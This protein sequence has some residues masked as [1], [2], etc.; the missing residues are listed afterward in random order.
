MLQAAG[1]ELQ[2]VSPGDFESLL[3][4]RLRAMRPSLERL[5]RYDEQRARERL[6]AGFDPAHTWHV[7]VAGRR[8]GF[9]VLKTL[10][11]ALRLDHL[12]IDPGV[13]GQGLGGQVLQW[14]IARAED[15]QRPLELV[16]LKHSDAIRLYLRHGF[17]NTGQGEWDLD[18]VRWPS[19]RGMLSVRALWQAFQARDWPRAQALL[20]PQLQAVWWTSGERFASAEG[21]I[22]AQ[23]RYPEG[24]TIRLIEL[25]ALPDGRVLSVVRVDHP[26]AQFFATS[27]FRIDDG[28]ILGVDEYWAS[29]EP[30]PDWRVQLAL[31]GWQRMAGDEEDPRAREP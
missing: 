1:F 5:G 31:P 9:V 8:V 29:A 17:V 11:H 2:G 28:L 15:A 18:F 27:F 16:A 24:W 20:H 25:S 26:P 23:S 7:V 21:F 12:Y 10:S 6:A 14:A 30:P 22:Q 13:Q 3:A 19:N 4:L